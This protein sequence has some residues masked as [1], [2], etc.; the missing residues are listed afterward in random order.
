MYW[1]YL[2][3]LLSFEVV[4]SQFDVVHDFAVGL[5]V[6]GRVAAEEDVEDDAC[7]PDVAAFVVFSGDDF[8]GDVVGLGMN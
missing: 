1:V 8:G 2:V 4:L 3:P 5:S 6:E 7:G